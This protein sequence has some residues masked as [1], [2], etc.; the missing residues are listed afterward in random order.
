MFITKYTNI[1]LIKIIVLILTRKYKKNNF[2][3]L[4][5][6]NHRLKF[7]YSPSARILDF[8]DNTIHKIRYENIINKLN[9]LK[10]GSINRNQAYLYLIR[11]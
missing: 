4:D 11:R 2:S 6:K 8:I 7:L 10:L 5:F 1:I 3:K 9:Q